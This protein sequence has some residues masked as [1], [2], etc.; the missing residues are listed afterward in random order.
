MSPLAVAPEHGPVNGLFQVLTMHIN[1]IRFK[2]LFQHIASNKNV[3]KYST[4]NTKDVDFLEY[5]QKSD[6]LQFTGLNDRNGRDIYEGDLL[7]WNESVVEVVYEHGSFKVLHD[8]NSD[9]LLWYCVPD[10][11]MVGSRFD[12]NSR[13]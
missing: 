11:E 6:W 5:S 12:R 4:V 13:I 1:N 3:W 2:A 9:I 7:K 8:G 10:C